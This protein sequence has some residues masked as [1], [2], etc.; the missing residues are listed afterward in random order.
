MASITSQHQSATLALEA[1]NQLYL[2]FSE[3]PMNEKD[4]LV[5]VILIPL[6]KCIR[7]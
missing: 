7:P 1:R 2:L 4:L 6:H 3:R 5:K